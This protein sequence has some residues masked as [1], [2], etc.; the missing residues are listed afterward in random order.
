[1]KT[2]KDAANHRNRR[3]SSGA[4]YRDIARLS[5]FSL[6]TVSFALS[7]NNTVKVS[8]KTRHHILRIARHL[9][10]RPDPGLRAWQAAT[11]ARKGAVIR[12]ALGWIN[13][14][15][16][17][18]WWTPN[19][20][21]STLRESAI[22]R[23][24]ELGYR[25]DDIWLPGSA[26][27][28]P[29]VYVSR[30]RAILRARGITGIVLPLMDYPGCADVDWP[31]CAVVVIGK[32]KRMSHYL[33]Q[34]RK[35]PEV[36]QPTLHHAVNSD[37]FY[38][39]ALAYRSLVAAGYRRIGFV[40]SLNHDMTSDQLISSAVENEMRQ[41]PA[42]RRAPILRHP[43]Q[44]RLEA[45]GPWIRKHRPDAILAVQS[46]VKPELDRL[47]IRVPEDIGLAHMNLKGDVPHW[48]G[49]DRC[50]SS[51]GS[52][53][54]D[55]LASCLQRNELG[56]PKNPIEILVKGKWIDG[57]TTQPQMDGNP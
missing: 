1:M 11:R 55:L 3:G 41:V 46:E 51:I 18:D 22:R 27:Y 43:R 30:C 7:S 50:S 48:S 40:T 31:G 16:E 9:K 24:R 33:R 4:T 35:H 42:G 12:A 5:G 57:R 23:A 56:P 34:I 17:R 6:A 8:A 45:L 2:F 15:G 20:F 49:I 14:H 19:L 28:P 25:M 44:Y 29:P 21:D 37:Y 32:S 13:D 39:G 52:A 47:K 26:D 10:Y 38:N 53:A 36:L 54:I